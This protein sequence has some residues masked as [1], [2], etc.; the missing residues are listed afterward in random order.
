MAE[1]ARMPSYSVV[2]GVERRLAEV[3][4]HATSGERACVFDL[5]DGSRRYVLE[6]EW[7]AGA[8]LFRA[9]A[10]ERGIV[11]TQ[12][13][14]AD[15]VA[16]FRSLFRGREDVY[17]HG[18]LK[19]DGKIGYAPACANERTRNCPRWNRTN[20]GMKCA[21]CPSREHVSLSDEELVRHFRG[22]DLEFRDV[23]GLYVLTG[24]CKAWVLAAD[25]D[26]DGWE[27]EVALYC[28]AC[29]EHG[30]APSI[31]RSRSGNGAHVWLFFEDAV[32][33]QLARDL[34]SALISWAMAHGSGMGFSAYDRLFP[35]Q[36][37]LTEDGLG[38]LIALPLQGR[39]KAQG[40]S[41]FVNEDLKE[42]P[43]QWRYLS[44]VTRVSEEKA[45]EVVASIAGGPLG[46]LASSD[47]IGLDAPPRLVLEYLGE[48]GRE[49]LGRPDF[50]PV[51]EVTKASM[52][53]VPKEGLSPRAQNRVRRLAA[54]ANPEFYKAQAQH[55]YAKNISRIVWCG[56]EDDDRIMLPRCCEG[57]LMQLVRGAGSA[58]RTDDRRNRGDPIRAEFVGTLWE[59]QRRAVDAL[60]S[61]EDGILSAPTGS[62]KTVV[63]AYL[64]AALKMRTLVLV[65]K[66]VLVGQWVEKLEA[67]LS[68]EDDRPPLL[69]KTGRPSRRR[70]PVIGRIGGGKTKPSGIVDVATYQSLIAKDDLGAPIAKPLAG[71]YDLVICDECHHG[72][73]P[74]FELVMRSVN[75]RRIYGLS[76]TP[77]RTD[78]LQYIYFMQCGPIRC[79]IE[80]K[81]QAKRQGF[82]RLLVPRL[83]RVRLGDVAPGTSF[84]QVVDLLC[85]H[86]ARNRII[87]GDVATAVRDG[88][89]PLVLTRRKAHATE[90]AGLLEAEG[91]AVVVLTGGGTARERRE[92]LERL[93][94]MGSEPHAVVATGSYAG[95]GLDLPCLDTLMLA[96]PYSSESV[97]TQ[98]TGRLHREAEG[99]RDAVVYDYV[100]T[101]VP[102]LERMYKRR[103][104]AYARLGYEAAKADVTEG[105]GAS[106]VDGSGWLEALTEDISGAGRGV[107]IVAPYAS[108]KAVGMLL[109]AIS[110]AVAR[111][112]SVSIAVDEPSG[113]DAGRRLAS[114]VDELA[115]AGCEARVARLAVT[116]IAV[117]DGR[118]AWFGSLPL[119]AL[120]KEGDCSL[121]VV[122]AEAAADVAEMVGP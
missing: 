20:R 60:L 95:E 18:Y 115:S 30:L 86:G 108:A 110:G 28:G 78:G 101:S 27:R 117:V 33:A 87:A 48:G 6:P 69:T 56:M 29:R 106:L 17:A 26:K 37:T 88:R 99:K 84:N 22:D 8:E 94:A 119:L 104:K 70:R 5:V 65:P 82:R 116:G 109:P 77:K 53:L 44:S 75:A 93:G 32:D 19:R 111:G 71:E 9:A 43:D 62:G 11:T 54:F 41:V 85:G 14:K 47:D 55:R 103:L 31:E 63:A 113:A 7:L 2:D 61:H 38:N 90:L 64:I 42:C 50:P 76:A 39:A 89:T 4:T 3:V 12:S 114:V 58:C 21:E 79:T 23:L 52:L 24:E 97:V 25:F 34:G 81:E 45:R 72:S 91:V 68:I 73:A 10:R 112:V 105:D 57:A 46:R 1:Q 59:L 15:K 96:N 40:N 80:A 107:R 74:S 122:S 102:M 83:T 66:S 13:P 16:L 36:S 98:F 100:D 120:P 51:V 121:R 118:I 49:E 67:F 92:R 35:T